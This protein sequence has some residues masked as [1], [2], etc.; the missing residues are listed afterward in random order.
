MGV[1]FGSYYQFRNSMFFVPWQDMGI[2]GYYLISDIG[3]PISDFTSSILHH[4]S[5][6]K[7]GYL[8]VFK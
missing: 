6:I 1:L 3:C 2:Y 5:S 4:P 8:W 7:Y